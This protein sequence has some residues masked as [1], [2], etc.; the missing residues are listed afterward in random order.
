[1]D[2]VHHYTGIESPTSRSA[3]RA[4]LAEIDSELDELAELHARTS[5]RIEQ[6]ETTRKPVASAL[7]SIVYPILTLPV[8]MTSEIFAHYFNEV[9]SDVDGLPLCKLRTARDG[10]PLILSQVCR[11]WRNIAINTHSM[12]CRVH[13]S[14]HNPG[15]PEWRNFLECWLSRA[16]NRMLYLDLIVD[17]C[18]FTKLFTTV[19][20]YSAHWRVF[21]CCIGCDDNWTSISTL[22]DT[23]RGRTPLLHEFGVWW[24]GPSDFPTTAPITAFSDAPELRKVTLHDLPSEKITL[25]WAQLTHLTLSGYNTTNVIAVLH[26]TESLEELSIDLY[27]SAS[28]GTQP[29]VLG[30]VHRL[31]LPNSFGYVTQT[32]SCVTLPKLRSL[33]IGQIFMAEHA[34]ALLTFAK[35]S[36]CTLE[37]IS[38]PGDAEQHLTMYTLESKAI[39]TASHVSVP[40]IDWSV[41]ELEQFFSWIAS[42]SAFLPNMRSLHLPRCTTEVPFAALADMLSS[43]SYNRAGQSRL[44]SFRLIQT[45]R[46]G[47]DHAIAPAMAEQLRDLM[48]DGLDIHIESINGM[49]YTEKFSR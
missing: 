15:R 14:A 20:P 22:V 17:P 38:V 37:T 28:V 10:G 24:E 2:P 12:W 39:R 5:A 19:V 42:D 40:D 49:G 26:L 1:M 46:Q 16:G 44:E 33:E 6:L 13:A 34:D 3:F 9:L 27:G 7:D 30:R 29:V 4:R 47:P 25:P 18:H 8:E 31:V 23:V 48:D 35:R 11:A 45:Y 43:R 32:L 21:K 36:H 41:Y